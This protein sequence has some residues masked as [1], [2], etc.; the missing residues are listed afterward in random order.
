MYLLPAESHFARFA[1]VATTGIRLLALIQSEGHD[2]W[3]DSRRWVVVQL[4]PNL[5]ALADACIPDWIA[6]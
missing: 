5:I 2:Y 4:R 6:G 1:V 3:I